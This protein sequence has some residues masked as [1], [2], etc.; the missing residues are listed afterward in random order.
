MEEEWLPPEFA[1]HDSRTISGLEIEVGRFRS[2]PETLA[3]CAP[4]EVGKEMLDPEVLVVV[5]PEL[6]FAGGI[7]TVH[8]SL[9]QSGSNPGQA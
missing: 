4:P 8:Q 1:E 6:R 7:V 3:L 5:P 2:R 9:L